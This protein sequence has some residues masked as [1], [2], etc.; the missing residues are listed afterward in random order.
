MGFRGYH[1]NKNLI[2]GL[3]ATVVLA[4]AAVLLLRAPAAMDSAPPAQAQASS[5][6]PQASSQIAATP[7]SSPSNGPHQSSQLPKSPESRSQESEVRLW[8]L[9]DETPDTMLDGNPAK[10]LQTDPELVEAFHVGQTLHLDIPQSNLTLEAQLDSTYNQ[11]ANV[12]IFRGKIPGGS[13]DDNVIVTR[14]KIETHLVIATKEGTYT[15]IIDNATGQT[16][17]IDQAEINTHQIPFDD[18]IPVEP[19]EQH[20]PPAG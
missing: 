4:A 16:T 5:G 9:D 10:R 17:L 3:V 8:Q 11:S 14:G 18:G 2:L 19:V 15:A 13:P 12:H 1:V 20:P 7:P 6:W